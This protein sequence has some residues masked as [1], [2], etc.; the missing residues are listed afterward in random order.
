MDDKSKIVVFSLESETYGFDMEYVNV[1]E[2]PIPISKM[3]SVPDFIE[4]LINLRGD[5]YTLF[6]LRKQF[7]LTSDNEIIENIKYI[8]TNDNVGR[9]GFIVDDVNEIITISK[10]QCIKDLSSL[11]G[12]IDNLEIRKHILSYIKLE[13]K[14]IFL[15]D[16]N[17]LITSLRQ[18]HE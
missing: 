17:E 9:V 7:A 11:S 12:A 6:N 3:P 13:N 2:T 15:L 14:T 8:I 18:L 10:D 1:I 4:G 5:I 16:P